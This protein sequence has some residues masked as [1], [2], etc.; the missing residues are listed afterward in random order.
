MVLDPRYKL[1]ISNQL[2]EQSLLFFFF[3]FTLSFSTTVTGVY[4]VV[5]SDKGDSGIDA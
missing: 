5:A 4:V 3:G 1:V 2:I